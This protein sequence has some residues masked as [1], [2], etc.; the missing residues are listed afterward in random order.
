MPP[1]AA[2][3]TPAYLG[4]LFLFNQQRRSMNIKVKIL[5]ICS[6]CKGISYLPAGEAVDTKG[7]VYMR[8]LPCTKCHGSG[9]SGTW[10]NLYEFKQ[11]LQQAE[12]PHEHVVSNGG[13]HYSEGEIWDDLKEVCSDCGEILD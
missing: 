7:E 11:L 5:S 12:C 2:L 9:M 4:G 8:Y 6:V 3:H 1:R 10:I 13:H